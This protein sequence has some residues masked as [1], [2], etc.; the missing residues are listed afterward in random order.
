MWRRVAAGIALASLCAMAVHAETIRVRAET[1][2]FDPAS[3]AVHPGDMVEWTNADFI[4]H[5]ATARDGRF[6]VLIMPGK[7]AH[8]VLATGA[9]VDYYCRFHPNMTG[10]IVVGGDR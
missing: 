2:T 5:T 8:V 7:T 3:I 1:L 10:H 9:P 6:D 4:A